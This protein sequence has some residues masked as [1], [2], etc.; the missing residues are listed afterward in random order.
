MVGTDSTIVAKDTWSG[1]E[2]FSGWQ[3]IVYHDSKHYR[4]HSECE[5]GLE[6]CNR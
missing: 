5:T 2:T 3:F 6:I 4:E 1:S